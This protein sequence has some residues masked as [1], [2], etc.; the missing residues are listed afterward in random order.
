LN[1]KQLQQTGTGEHPIHGA[2]MVLVMLC[3]KKSIQTKHK[4][5]GAEENIVK[6]TGL[7]LYDPAGFMWSRNQAIPGSKKAWRPMLYIL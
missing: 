5:T 7:W 6:L 4:A 2:S 3:G 1:K